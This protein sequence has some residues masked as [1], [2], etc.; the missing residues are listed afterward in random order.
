MNYLPN[1]LVCRGCGAGPTNFSTIYNHI[2]KTV[3]S[4]YANFCSMGCILTHHNRQQ[5]KKTGG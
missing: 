2:T 5:T 1:D 3:I 4:K